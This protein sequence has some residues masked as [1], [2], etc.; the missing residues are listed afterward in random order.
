MKECLLVWQP[1]RTDAGTDA[2]LLDEEWTLKKNILKSK[3]KTSTQRSCQ[4]SSVSLSTNN[5][6]VPKTTK[7]SKTHLRAG[8]LILRI[9]SQRERRGKLRNWMSDDDGNI[10]K[11]SI[12]FLIFHSIPS[13]HATVFHAKCIIL[14]SVFP[15]FKW[16]NS[17]A[18]SK[19]RATKKSLIVSNCGFWEK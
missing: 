15:E 8:A 11:P 12:V 18:N 19:L 3:V 10:I 13:F 9:L 2:V 1:F 16:E 7:E 6:R 4:M 14:F 17:T 5:F